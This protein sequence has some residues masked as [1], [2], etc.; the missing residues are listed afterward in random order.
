MAI[1]SQLK[2]R[3]A[4]P[5]FGE[6]KDLVRLVEQEAIWGMKWW[7]GAGADLKSEGLL[8][9]MHSEAKRRG[10]IFARLEPLVPMEEPLKLFGKEVLDSYLPRHTLILNLELSEQELLAQMAQ[11]GR[12]NIRQA[13][14]A[15]VAVQE[16][17]LTGLEDFYSLLVDTAKRDGFRAHPKSFYAAFLKG[18]GQ[19]GARLYMAR[20]DGEAVAGVLITYY[21]GVATYYF[22][23]SSSLDR[24]TYASYLLQWTAI[25]DAKAAGMKVYDFLGIAPEGGVKDPL[26]GV[27][28]FKT[29]FG[30]KR[31]DYHPAQ[32]IVFRPFWYG[33]YKILKGL[34]KIF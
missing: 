12:Y 23:A 25:R 2:G 32:V 7:W 6:E 1:Q 15:G 18:L 13:E 5:V 26:A 9:E 24:K 8:E 19:E 17:G 27:T 33:V 22:G 16:E 28:Q 14:K 34:R 29:R 11:K 30:G 4:G 3:A 20:V 10:V 21:E 31:V